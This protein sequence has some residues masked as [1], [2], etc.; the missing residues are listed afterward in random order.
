MD[1]T[2]AMF[3]CRGCQ[4]TELSTNYDLPE[5]EPE[6]ITDTSHPDYN[7]FEDPN[8][9]FFGLSVNWARTSKRPVPTVRCTRIKSDGTQCKNRSRRG[10]GLT[11]TG[12][13]G[14]CPRHGG[15]LPSLKAHADAVVQAARYQLVDSAPD[16]LNTIM[17]LLRDN[18]TPQAVRLA[19][20][21]DVLDRANIK[22][23]TD[24]N[25]EVTQ[26]EAPS[27]K[28]MKKLEDMRKKEEPTLEDLGEAVAEEGES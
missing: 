28:L 20:A 19:A 2:V 16:A 8:S 9:P 21:R 18:D 17:E 14:L 24:I 4:L 26:N 10:L 15:N 27:V 25:I 5:F 12:P 11:K 1:F 6:I 7:A 22:G 13:P 3:D 23:S